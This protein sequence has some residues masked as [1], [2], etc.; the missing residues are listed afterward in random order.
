MYNYT[1]SDPWYSGKYTDGRQITACSTKTPNPCRVTVSLSAPVKKTL[2]VKNTRYTGDKLEGP[3]WALC[4]FVTE[5][6]EEPTCASM[7]DSGAVDFKKID[8]IKAV[9][10]VTVYGLKEAKEFVESMGVLNAVIEI[11][12]WVSHT[13]KW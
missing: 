13:P 1:F 3:N 2:R 5:S 12:D 11:V 9:R 7:F 6:E 8:C 10:S 4:D